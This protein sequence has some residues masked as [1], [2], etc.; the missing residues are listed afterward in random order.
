MV[1]MSVACRLCEFDDYHD[2]VQS[3]DDDDEDKNESDDDD[4]GGGGGNSDFWLVSS[5]FNGLSDHCT[6]TTL[7]L[8]QKYLLP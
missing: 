6:V 8:S 4:D 2:N 1:F 3:D 7:T 5:N